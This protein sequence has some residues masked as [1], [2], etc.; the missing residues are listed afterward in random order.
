MKTF[1]FVFARGG[2]KGLPGKNIKPLAGKPLLAHAIELAKASSVIDGVFVSTDDA[3]IADVA[4]QHGAIVIERP[5]ALATDTS[6]EWLSWRHAV[7]WVSKHY[8]AF[9]IFVSLPATSPIRRIGDVEASIERI[10]NKDGDIC[11]SIAKTH[12]NPF[13]NVV[14]LREDG[15]V[16]LMNTPDEIIT[17]RQDAPQAFDIVTSFYT[18]TPDYILTQSGI[19]QGRVS[20]VEIPKSHAVDI[21]DI[22][23]FKLAEIMIEEV[24]FEC[25]A[26]K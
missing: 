1:A 4:H 3:G 13:F 22:Y 12:R 10:K 26:K 16:E 5:D 7:E 17:R 8:G 18:T 23:D 24:G 6:P 19:F 15:L 21:D 2:S 25:A 11:I 20:H 14:K 9:D